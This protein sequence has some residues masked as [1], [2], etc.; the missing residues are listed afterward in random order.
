VNIKMIKIMKNK[1]YYLYVKK[2]RK[3]KHVSTFGVKKE[4]YNL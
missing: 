3:L 1:L 4:Y 2:Q